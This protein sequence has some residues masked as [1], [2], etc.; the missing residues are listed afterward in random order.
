MIQGQLLKN[1]IF[2]S[3][4]DLFNKFNWFLINDLPNTNKFCR[5]SILSS[6]VQKLADFLND[7]LIYDSN[8]IIFQQWHL[9]ALEIIE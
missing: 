6:I 1:D 9:L 2:S 8:T 5:T 7:E 3:P 4:E